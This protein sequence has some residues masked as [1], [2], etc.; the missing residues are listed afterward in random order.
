MRLSTGR[1]AAMN[2]GAKVFPS[3]ERTRGNCP[4][5]RVPRPRL[6]QV[7][8]TRTS[9][10]PTTKKGGMWKWDCEL[11]QWGLR[12][13]SQRYWKCERR[14]GLPPNA[15]LSVVCDARDGERTHV[16]AFHVTFHIGLDHLH[17]YYH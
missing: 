6:S 14:F 12:R 2:R 1:S 5:V 9:F 13:Q 16:G 3:G 4:M 7:S 17:F 11:R 8:S 15:H 10:T